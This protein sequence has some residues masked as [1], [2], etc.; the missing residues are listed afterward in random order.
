[1][2]NLITE[3]SKYLIICLAAFYTY[4]CFAVFRK[5]YGDFERKKIYKRQMACVYLIHL[6]AFL[7]LFAATLNLEM[8]GMSS[9]AADFFPV[10]TFRLYRGL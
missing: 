4:E 9:R 2:L 8:I 5:K 7:V 6:D 1:M 3:I 10:V